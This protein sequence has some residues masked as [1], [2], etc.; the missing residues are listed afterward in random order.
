MTDVPPRSEIDTTV[1]HDESARL[2]Q[3]SRE[4]MERLDV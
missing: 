3:V 1:W 2:E 4:Q